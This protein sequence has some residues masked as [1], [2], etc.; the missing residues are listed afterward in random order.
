MT[1]N[2]AVGGSNP[3][4]RTK[5]Q[6]APNRGPF[7][8]GSLEADENLPVRQTRQRLDRAAKPRVRS[9]KTAQ[10]LFSVNP[11]NDNRKMPGRRTGR[12]SHKKV[13]HVR[14]QAIWRV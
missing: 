1:T 6:R 12:V 8:L 7:F 10:A 3:S 14:Q 11:L 13:D 9:L 4:G 2:Q 5:R